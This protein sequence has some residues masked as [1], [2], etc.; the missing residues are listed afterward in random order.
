MGGYDIGGVEG[1]RM[2]N[3]GKLIGV[4]REGKDYIMTVRTPDGSFKDFPHD[5]FN[6][7][8]TKETDRKKKKK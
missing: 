3:Y 1:L 7:P 2:T 6:A 4:H 8:L 5:G